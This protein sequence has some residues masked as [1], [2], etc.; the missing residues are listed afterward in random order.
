[1]STQASLTNQRLDAA[2]RFLNMEIEQKWMALAY[3][4]AALFHL[5]SGFMGLLQ[6]IKQ[7]YGLNCEPKLQTMLLA[8][9][10][11][12]FEI[13]VLVELAELAANS[14][15]WLNRL[16]SAYEASLFCHPQLLNYKESN[17]ISSSS[18]DKEINLGYLTAL[19]DIIMRFREESVEY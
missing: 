14:A 13:P 10:K 8:A 2:R 9:K 1:M 15:S 12:E 18:N 19:S 5:Q 11:Q 7:L 16:M 17:I 6:E 4:N 3:E